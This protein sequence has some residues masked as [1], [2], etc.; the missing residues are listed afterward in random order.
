MSSTLI[1]S[2]AAQE[3]GDSRKSRIMTGKAHGF[4]I[5][6][7]ESR[8]PTH[9]GVEIDD[10]FSICKTTQNRRIKF[11]SQCLSASVARRQ[12]EMQHI[13]HLSDLYITARLGITL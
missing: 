6:V 7:C 8:I 11:S 10:Y 1:L 2:R 3:W 12:A 9:S 4:R 5:P 13:R